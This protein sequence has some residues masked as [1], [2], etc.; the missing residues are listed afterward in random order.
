MT[1][2]GTGRFRSRTGAGRSATACGM[3]H[4]I[5]GTDAHHG[6][7]GPVAF[8]RGETPHRQSLRQ[9]VEQLGQRLVLT[10][11]VGPPVVAMAFCVAAMALVT[12]ASSVMRSKPR[13]GS[14]ALQLIRE[15]AAGDAPAT[16]VGRPVPIVISCTSRST[17]KARSVTSRAP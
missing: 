7:L 17:R 14:Q 4:G 8:A 10:G 1:I 6:S 2:N 13:S 12:P 9:A 15:Q 3:G 5:E 11:L 16:R